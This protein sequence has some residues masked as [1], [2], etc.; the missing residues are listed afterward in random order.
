MGDEVRQQLADHVTSMAQQV[1][2][3]CQCPLAIDTGI[4]EHACH[5]C[6]WDFPW[7]HICARDVGA[8]LT[9]DKAPL[10]ALSNL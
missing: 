1:S 4:P 10:Q 8:P 3:P 7:L 6:I 5:V 9:A 2:C